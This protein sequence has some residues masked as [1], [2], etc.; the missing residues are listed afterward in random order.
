MVQTASHHFPAAGLTTVLILA[1]SHAVLHSWPESGTVHLDIFSCS[2]S[3]DSHAAIDQMI[4]AF[5]AAM[6]SPSG[7]PTVLHVEIP[8]G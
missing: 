2:G 8:C 1:E 6:S 3:L 5:G 7:G 4:R